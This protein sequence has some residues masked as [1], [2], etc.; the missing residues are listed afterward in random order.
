[1]LVAELFDSLCHVSNMVINPVTANSWC[2]N[3]TARLVQE[4]GRMHLFCD[5]LVSL[6]HEAYRLQVCLD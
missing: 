6:K 3:E 4:T 1:M 5:S 2:V